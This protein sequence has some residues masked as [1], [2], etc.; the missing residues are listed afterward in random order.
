MLDES[1]LISNEK[2]KRSKFILS[3]NPTNVILLSGTPTAGKYEQLWSQCKLL[4]WKINKK[5]FWSSYIITNWID[6]GGFM[7]EI[8]VGYKNVEHLKNKLAEYGAV[9]MKTEEVLDLPNQIDQKIMLQQDKKYKKFK[10]D[11]YLLL[12]D[13]TELVGDNSLT[14]ILYERQLCG[15]YSMEKREAFRNLIDSTE[16]RLIVFYN[17]TEEMEILK[18]IAIDSGKKI[19][20]VNGK[21]KDLSAYEEFNNSVTFVQYQAGAMGLNLQKANKII[22]YT[23]PLGKGSCDL[24]E[25]SKNI[26]LVRTNL[27]FIIIH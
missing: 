4:G 14:K 2:A 10:K 18:T 17:F 3:L 24:W 7:H 25:Q 5:T 27:V 16:D 6:V 13:G 22:Y 15:Q 20:I 9:F 11:H 26:V 8:V 19:S 1:S 23:L 21:T 12:E